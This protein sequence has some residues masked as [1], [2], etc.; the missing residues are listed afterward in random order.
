[1][2]AKFKAGESAGTYI[3]DAP[4]TEADIVEMAQHLASKRLRKGQALHQPKEVFSYLQLL[5]QDYEHEV[6][7]LLL[8]DSK[9]RVIR[10]EEL[11][12]GTLDSASVYPREVV[13]VALEHNAAAIVLVHTAARTADAEFLTAIPASVGSALRSLRRTNPAP[14]PHPKLCRCDRRASGRN[15][16]HQTATASNRLRKSRHHG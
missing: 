7:A 15:C 11:F 10:F 16:N 12:R 1:M 4:V 6:F 5:L 14:G 8:L 13:K 2:T 9:H 3:A